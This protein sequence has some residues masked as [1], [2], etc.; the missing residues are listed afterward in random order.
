MLV[1]HHGDAG[2]GVGVSAG[3]L[4]ETR[5]P[6]IQGGIE[7]RQVGGFGRLGKVTHFHLEKGGLL[8]FSAFACLVGAA[9]DAWAGGGLFGGDLEGG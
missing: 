8:F 9:I 2:L 7:V 3:L 6:R 5:R 1:D 4:E